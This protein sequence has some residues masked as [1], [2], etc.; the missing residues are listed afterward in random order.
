[1]FRIV[2]IASL[3]MLVPGCPGTNQRACERLFAH[4]R[5]LPCDIQESDAFVDGFFDALCFVFP[6]GPECDFPSFTDCIVRNYTCDIIESDPVA[7]ESLGVECFESSGLGSIECLAL[8]DG[9][10][11]GGDSCTNNPC[12]D[13]L[14]CNGFETCTFDGGQAECSD[15][16]PVPCDFPEFCTEPYG[17]CRNPCGGYDCSDDIACTTDICTTEEDGTPTCTNVSVCD[18]GDPCNGVETCDAETG[19]C[20]PG[21]PFECSDGEICFNGHCLVLDPP[22]MPL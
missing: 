10:A 3:L 1:M 15:G 21:R 17:N 11:P 6:D 8:I 7:A 5:A 14:A 12:N 22:P 9:T 19:D 2:L 16:T 13:S 18:D 4:I 20:V